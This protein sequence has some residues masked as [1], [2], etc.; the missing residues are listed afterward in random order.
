MLF[1]NQVVQALPN[2]MVARLKNKR[3][4]AV[5]NFQT[6][7]G[8]LKECYPHL[9]VFGSLPLEVFEINLGWW[10]A[11]IL[12]RKTNHQLQMKIWFLYLLNL[13]CNPSNLAS[14]STPFFDT[15]LDIPIAI[16]KGMFEE[17]LAGLKWKIAIEEMNALKKN[18]TWGIVDLP[19]G[20]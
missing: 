5:L 10:K 18:G 20:K 3:L 9:S 16:R 14:I 2:N 1:I 12:Q 8:T 15:N 17:T 13:F 4:L 7:I 11:P 19:K 6:P